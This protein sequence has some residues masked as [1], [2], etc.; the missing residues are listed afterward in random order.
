M[1]IRLFITIAMIDKLPIWTS[2]GTPMPIMDD[3]EESLSR[4]PLK[5][6]E[7]KRVKKIADI[8]KLTNCDATVAAADPA[9][10]PTE[11]ENEDGVK[12]YVE[13][14]RDYPLQ[15]GI[16]ELP[17]RAHNRGKARGKD[18]AAKD[19]GEVDA[20]I[21]HKLVGR[22]HCLEERRHC[23]KSDYGDDDRNDVEG[24]HCV[25][26]DRARFVRFA[27]A[28]LYGHKRSRAASYSR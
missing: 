9:T 5:L 17:L 11:G 21:G 2:A 1:P 18:V 7:V 10:P 22:A 16:D 26:R 20:G 6:C 15:G 23:R 19:Y 24:Y 28:E 14:Y 3:A 4:A 25:Q 12:H 8:T 27:L 13:G